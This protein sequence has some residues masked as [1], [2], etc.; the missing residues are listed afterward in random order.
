MMHRNLD[1][2]VELL[3]R[4]TDPAQRAELRQLI[5]LAM[6]PSDRV[7]VAGRRRHLDPASPRRSPAQPL[8]DIQDL[9]IR[10]RRG[11]RPDG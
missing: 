6:D 1:R 9:L 4:V 8:T 3:V 2:R 11:R 7:V 5:D 10:T